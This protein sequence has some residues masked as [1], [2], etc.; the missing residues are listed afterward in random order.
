M[1]NKAIAADETHNAKATD[2]NEAVGAGAADRTDA[3]VVADEVN[4]SVL[5]DDVEAADVDETDKANK[6]GNKLSELLMAVV[7]LIL[8]F[9]LTKYSVIFTEVEGDFAK[10]INNQLK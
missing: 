6:V 2:A 1:S 3:S 9:S 5:A 7:V 4:A 10:K 8:V